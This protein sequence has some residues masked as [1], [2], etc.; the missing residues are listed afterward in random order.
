LCQRQF[1]QIFP[2]DRPRLTVQ[3]ARSQNISVERGRAESG[4]GGRRWHIEFLSTAAN[5]SRLSQDSDPE[6]PVTNLM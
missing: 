5:F 3:R 6:T 4:S 1:Y 2:N